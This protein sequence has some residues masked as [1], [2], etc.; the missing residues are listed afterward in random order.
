ME[1]ISG[2]IEVTEIA[3]VKPSAASKR[4]DAATGIG[5]HDA[6]ARIQMRRPHRWRLPS[7]EPNLQFDT[8]ADHRTTRRRIERQLRCGDLTAASVMRSSRRALTKGI[9]DGAA[10]CFRQS[11]GGR[12]DESKADGALGNP[13]LARIA[14][15]A[16]TA[17]IQVCAV[18]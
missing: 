6:V 5:A 18:R 17:L 16:G 2:V 12:P 9:D 11:R 4:S 15:N 13:S 7:I 3:G 8:I 1:E 14:S 10:D